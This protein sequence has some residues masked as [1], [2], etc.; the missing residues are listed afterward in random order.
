[1]LLRHKE[2]IFWEPIFY[3]KLSL[4]LSGGRYFLITSVIF[5]MLR[6]P[7]FRYSFL[8]VCICCFYL[9]FALFTSHGPT[10][11]SLIHILHWW[12]KGKYL[13]F[14]LLL[15]LGIFFF[16]SNHVR[17]GF[18]H[19]SSHAISQGSLLSGHLC[20]KHRLLT[21]ATAVK[22]PGSLSIWYALWIVV[23]HF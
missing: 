16:V 20:L 13:L 11:S 17:L 14:L 23:T 12:M 6:L 2:T 22:N 1:M 4:A 5:F 8:F 3:N 7:S 15:F 18:P 9:I 10:L 19:A 21:Y